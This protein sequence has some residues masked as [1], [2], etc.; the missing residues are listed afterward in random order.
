MLKTEPE[1]EFLFLLSHRLKENFRLAGKAGE[2][3]SSDMMLAVSPDMIEGAVDDLF[4]SDLLD[5]KENLR[6]IIIPTQ[7]CGGSTVEVWVESGRG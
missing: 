2:L 6:G 3:G 4:R 7:G 5:E 1:S